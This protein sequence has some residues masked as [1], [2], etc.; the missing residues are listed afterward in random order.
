MKFSRKQ[1]TLSLLLASLLVGSNADLVDM[2]ANFRDLYG[3]KNVVF[4]A[5]IGGSSHIT[6][7]L[8]IGEELAMRGHNVSFLTTREEMRFGKPYE[9][10]QTVDIG[11][12]IVYDKTTFVKNMV[13]TKNV[14]KMMSSLMQV[15]SSQYERDF[16]SFVNYFKDTNTDVVMCDHF[17]E[18]CIDA[19]KVMK[20]PVIITAAMD[21]SSETAAPY[22]NNRIDNMED[23]TTEFQSFTE[24]F[25]NKFYKPLNAIYHFW[26]HVQ[27]M[28]AR[29]KALGIEGK[30]ESP[31]VA[32]KDYMKLVNN[33]HG[34]TAARPVGP[35]AEYVG[36]I[37][38]KQYKPLTNDLKEYLDSHERVAY[39]AFGQN[40]VPT[41]KNIELIL[42]GLLESLEAG[43]L[44]GFLWATVHSAGFFPDT[45][46]TASGTTYNVNDMINHVNPHARMI[47]WAPQ[48][49]V[50]F[51]PSTALFV[52]HGGLGSWY[53]SMFSGTRMIMFPFFG[54]QPGNALIIERNQLG[55]ILDAEGSVKDAIDLFKR[56]TGD[57][58]GEIQKNVQRMQSLTQIHSEHGIMRGA[59]V[60]EEVAYTHKDGKLPHRESANRRMSYVKANNLDLYAAF[61][62]F[63]A[64]LF[65]VAF[66]AVRYAF[67]NASDKKNL[68]L[69][70]L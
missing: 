40:A 22:V 51:H 38:P 12:G 36:P 66:C 5:T 32:W 28:T 54:D 65:G 48:T 41:E 55:G 60:V 25:L 49:A 3:H 18:A 6:W 57:E 15:M 33:L 21:M 11:P 7:A 20:L 1:S 61:I 42:L 46:T 68:K 34:Y 13:A 52:S 47:K 56:V 43:Y 63:V 35:L 69:K 24:R 53:E 58:D 45:I 26:P 29:K 16:A 64:I 59:D 30:F 19:A 27:D 23:T 44:D 67:V 14:P 70:K 17:L 2:K 9:H 31:D 62:S 4:G 39:I 10:V 37:I 8:S 50:L